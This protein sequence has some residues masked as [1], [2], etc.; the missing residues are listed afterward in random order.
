MTIVRAPSARK[1]L[2]IVDDDIFVTDYLSLVLA[3]LNYDVHVAHNGM[4]GLG[5]VARHRPDGI[6]LDL[7]MPKMNGFEFLVHL[8]AIDRGQDTPVIVLSANHSSADV[9]KALRLGA[10]G[11]VAKP[12]EE[13]VLKQRLG[14]LVPNPP[15]AMPAST[16]VVWDGTSPKSLL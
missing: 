4:S 7:A 5:S 10:K 8:K 6:I 13:D 14:R 2:L 16:H 12:V 9:Q 11:Y 1:T 15:Y 3:Q